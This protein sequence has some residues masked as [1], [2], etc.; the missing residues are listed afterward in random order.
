MGA[1]KSTL[2]RALSETLN[3]PY[4]DT[5]QWIESQT[6]STISELVDRHG[7][8]Y[9]RTLES[10][11]ITQ[12][13]FN[14]QSI[15]STG[16]GFPLQPFNASWLKSNAVSFYISL[17]SDDLFH[18]LWSERE[19]RPLLRGKFQ[20]ALRAYIAETLTEREDMYNKADFTLDGTQATENLVKEIIGLI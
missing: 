4:I 13:N 7:W 17:N 19:I 9:F 3:W 8:P 14:A 12:F 20:D 5:D 2:G 10:S 6:N 15:V 1:G 16:G 18:R 11:F